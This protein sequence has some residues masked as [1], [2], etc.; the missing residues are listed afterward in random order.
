MPSEMESGYPSE[1]VTPA[2]PRPRY[3][4]IRSSPSIR[5]PVALHLGR[6]PKHEAVVASE[7]CSLPPVRRRAHDGHPVSQR[8]GRA[9]SHRVWK[10]RL[11]TRFSSQS[12]T[13]IF[14]ILFSNLA[15]I[16]SVPEGLHF[17]EFQLARIFSVVAE[18]DLVTFDTLFGTL[19]HQTGCGE[20]AVEGFAFG[21]AR[22][23]R[24]ILL[25]EK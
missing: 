25:C 13:Q 6:T 4:L 11:G 10:L 12:L 20:G 8:H 9:R 1:S 21:E 14:D 23:V 22:P 3:R 5:S 18:V 17:T 24:V 15:F 7:F 16:I 19:Q 2:R